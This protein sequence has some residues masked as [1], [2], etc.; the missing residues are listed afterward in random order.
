MTATPYTAPAAPQTP[1]SDIDQR[2]AVPAGVASLAAAATSH[3]RDGPERPGE[4]SGHSTPLISLPPRHDGHC[5]GT[6]GARLRRPSEIAA[7]CHRLL[8]DTYSNS[9]A[10]SRINAESL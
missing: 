7:N 4:Q 10:D 3:D 1:G 5:D 6:S 8:W 2:T 9:L